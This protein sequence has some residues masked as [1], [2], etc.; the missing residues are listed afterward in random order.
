M[1]KHIRKL[2][3]FIAIIL[4]AV[5]CFSFT[6]C[7]EANITT[8]SVEI[9]VCDH[10]EGTSETKT[11]NIDLYGHLAPKTVAQIVKYVKEGYYNNTVFYVDTERSEQLMLGMI[12]LDADGNYVV[13]ELKPTIDVGEFKYGGTTGSNLKHEKGAVGLWRSWG[14]SDTYQSSNGF[15][16]G[17]AT[18]YMPM[19]S[20]LSGYDDY[21]CV[22]GK[23]NLENS[24]TTFEKLLNAFGSGNYEE[25]YMYYTGEFDE[26]ATNYG[27]QPH[28]ITADEYS[29]LSTEEIEAIFDAEEGQ[30]KQLVEFNKKKIRISKDL[31]NGAKSAVVNKIT[32]K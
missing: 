13:N 17:R 27:L 11:I 26:N 7:D 32:V 24:A 20:N 1:K 19:N 14:A 22:F 31:T 9:Q 2:V 5:F 3:N 23:I 15:G 28:I 4:V 8:I 21:F 25:Y 30:N 6:A 18:M 12:K 16:T 10:E 29:E